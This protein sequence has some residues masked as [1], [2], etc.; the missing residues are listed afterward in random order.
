MGAEFMDLVFFQEQTV[1]NDSKCVVWVNSVLE[2]EKLKKKSE[3]KQ[4]VV[5]GLLKTDDLLCSKAKSSG[6]EVLADCP[7]A[8]S[9][10]W[11]VRRKIDFALVRLNTSKPVIDLA[12]VN[13]AAENGVTLL[14]AL[15]DWWGE[16]VFRWPALFRNAFWVAK[17]CKKTKVKAA[18]ISGAKTKWQ[19]RGSKER[20]AFANWLGF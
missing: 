16:P 15:S 3:S 19:N 14:V 13:V 17:L 2:L 20:L 4:S 1:S 11:A 18:V 10:M 12:I 9:A 7:S 8:P 6:F 5:I